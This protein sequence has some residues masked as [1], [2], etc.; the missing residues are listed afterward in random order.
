MNVRLTE[1][2]KIKVLNGADLYAIMQQVLLREN[3]I[4]RNQEHFWM[5]GLD[6]H[7]K[8]LFIELISLGAGNRMVVNPPELFRM[9]IYKLAVKAILVH[10]HP[11]QNLQPSEADQNAT[12]RFLKVGKLI[13]IE[14]FDHLIINEEDFYSFREN[15]LMAQLA[16][17]NRYELIDAE[18]AKMLELQAEL[19]KQ[20]AVEDEKIAI[21]TKMKADG[22]DIDTIQKYTGLRK[23]EIRRL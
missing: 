5:V 13:N 3:K 15:Q 14:V 7:H 22:V 4:R 23:V 2:Q 8:I 20:R 1:E 17:N 11:N 12:D 9:A 18:R 21:A 16:L 6:D 19:K 10:N